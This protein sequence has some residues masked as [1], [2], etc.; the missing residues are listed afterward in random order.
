M[1]QSTV[2]SH[3]CKRGIWMAECSFIN[4]KATLGHTRSLVSG[5]HAGHFC[6]VLFCLFFA[7]GASV[8]SLSAWPY[9]AGLW[10]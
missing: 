3:Q 4:H 9:K 1:D 6:A 10:Q 5:Y 2:L 7:S 8:L